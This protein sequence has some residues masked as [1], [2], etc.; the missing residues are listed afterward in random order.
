MASLRG[1]VPVKPSALVL[2]AGPVT[3]LSLPRKGAVARRLPITWWQTHSWTK[4]IINL[5]KRLATRAE[6]QTMRPRVKGPRN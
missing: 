1:N 3:V 4:K 6:I 2:M 5:R